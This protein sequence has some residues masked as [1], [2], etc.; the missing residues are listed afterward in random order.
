MVRPAARVGVAFETQEKLGGKKSSSAW[1][2][3]F[4]R[5]SLIRSPINFPP[6][7]VAQS[8]E[9]LV[10]VERKAV[11]GMTNSYPGHGNRRDSTE[12]R[13]IRL[14]V[15]HPWSHPLVLHLVQQPY[16]A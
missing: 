12:D 13:I 2:V 14:A 3:L 6:L 9:E 8:A 5:E 7:Q 16:L 10:S 11:C 1:D 15:L 4:L